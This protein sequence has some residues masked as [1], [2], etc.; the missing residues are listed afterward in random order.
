M[1]YKYICTWHIPFLDECPDAVVLVVLS[2][3]FVLLVSLSGDVSV[4]TVKLSVVLPCI[5]VRLVDCACVCWDSVVDVCLLSLKLNDIWYCHP[6]LSL[7]KRSK[8][9]WLKQ[10]EKSHWIHW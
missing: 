9:K 1:K 4:P 3:R 10:M 2:V 6:I 8:E 5:F 7:M